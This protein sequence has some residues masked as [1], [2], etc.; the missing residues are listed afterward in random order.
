[1][2][3]VLAFPLM[4]GLLIPHYPHAKYNTT[5]LPYHLHCVPFLH[6]IDVVT[7]LVGCSFVLFYWSDLW[8]EADGSDILYL[9]LLYWWRWWYRVP[10]LLPLLPPAVPSPHP[11]MIVM[12]M[13]RFVAIQWYLT[14]VMMLRTV[15]LYTFCW[16]PV[17]I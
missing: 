6:S 5:H 8:L 4:F 7:I 13:I 9:V 16:L 1:M 12:M 10:L 3:S 11:P 2:P 14:V 15:V 17:K